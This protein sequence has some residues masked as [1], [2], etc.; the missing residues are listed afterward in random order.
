MAQLQP[1]PEAGG[2]P[3]CIARLSVLMLVGSCTCILSKQAA[4][5]H[6]ASSLRRSVNGERTI[7]ELS[8]CARTLQ[9]YV[10]CRLCNQ[11]S[12]GIQPR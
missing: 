10:L 3:S 12:T 5:R 7:A 4:I 11:A 9:R 6:R 8:H 1:V 2:A